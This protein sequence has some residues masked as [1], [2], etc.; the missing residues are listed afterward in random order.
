MINDLTILLLIH[1][2]GDFLFQPGEW[3]IKKITNKRA[4]FYHSLQYT[5]PFVIAFYFLNINLLWSFW[6]FGTHFLLDDRK[7]LD[8]WNH[9]IKREKKT[10]EWV[11][12]VQDQA[13]HVIAIAI[14]LIFT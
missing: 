6:I 1:F 10:P 2:A 8:W 4:L 9:K 3:A 7:F 11:V 5:L 12:M 13:L 14:L